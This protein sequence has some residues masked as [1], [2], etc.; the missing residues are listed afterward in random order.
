MY[1]VVLRGGTVIDGTGQP[2]YRADVAVEDGRIV[3]LGEVSVGEIDNV[4]DVG[5]AV[6][7]PGFIDMHSHSDISLVAFPW[8][9]SSLGQGI[10][11]EVVGNC[12]WSMAPITEV[13]REKVL[14]RL[15]GTLLDEEACGDTPFTWRTVGEFL[16]VLEQRGVGTNVVPLVGQSLVRACVMGVESERPAHPVELEVMKELVREAMSAG[17]WGMSTGRAYLPGAHAPTS[18]VVELARVVAREGGFYA[19]HMLD[20]GDRLLEALDEAITIGREAGIGVEISHLTACYPRNWGKMAKVIDRIGQARAEGVDVTFD[21]YPYPY[22]W[23]YPA[24]REFP[25]EVARLGAREAADFLRDPDRRAAVRKAFE[26]QTPEWRNS[27]RASGFGDV[28]MTAPDP[29]WVGKSI[30]DL[31]RERDADPVDTLIDLVIASEGQVGLS[32]TISE[33]DLRLAL[34]YPEAMVSTDAY[35]LDREIGT[36]VHPRHFG[37]MSRLLGV[38]VRE[39]GALSLEDAIRR[40]TSLP[41][42]RLGLRDRGVIQVGAAADLVVFDPLSI[43]DRATIAEPYRFPSG[44]HWV[45]VNGRVAVADGRHTGARAGKVLRRQSCGVPPR[46]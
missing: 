14:R 22:A 18:E 11:T 31:A 30:A 15:M 7:C 12:G 19:T 9:R 16:A 32:C 43:A 36:F 17:A 10:T 40:V 27:L 8:A 33:D 41:A 20:E 6:V 38:Y 23:V 2:G 25:P 45:L 44:I 28:V 5:G 24:H 37:A 35:A 26:G 42:R 21:L 3:S 4:I 29:A 1:D 34:R 13:V 39:Q 46:S